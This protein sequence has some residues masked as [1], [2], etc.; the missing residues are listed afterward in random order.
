MVALY[1]QINIH[2]KAAF[3]IILLKQ[4]TTLGYDT[5]INLIPCFSPKN[6]TSKLNI[7][8]KKIS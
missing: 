5:E 6:Q 4:S 2:N 1:Y 7:R 8:K 3:L